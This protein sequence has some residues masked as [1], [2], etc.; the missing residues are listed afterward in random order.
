M[1]GVLSIGQLTRSLR[2]WKI[3]SGLELQGMDRPFDTPTAVA[4]SADGRRAV[5]F[6]GILTV[7]DV[8]TGKKE[9]SLAEG[10]S[11]LFNEGVALSAN[12][13]RAISG[14]E[15]GFRVW[16]LES[17]RGYN[18]RGHS[19]MVSDVALTA[20]GRRAVS[21]CHDGT[22]RIWELDLG[23][24][25]RILQAHSDSVGS[26]AISADGRRV[27]SA[28]YDGTVKIWDADTGG[29]LHSFQALSGFVQHGVAMSADG[30]RVLFGSADGILNVWNTQTGL[31]RP[32]LT[33]HK[34]MSGV[35]LS[36]D[37]MRALSANAEGQVTAWDLE[38]GQPL[39]TFTCDNPVL[40]CALGASGTILAGDYGGGVHFLSLET[41]GSWRT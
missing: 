19:Q 34:R 29:L 24:E 22:L 13:R 39:A 20:D 28:S 17:G 3:D 32:I 26:V 2:V 31:Q 37:G 10:R 36:P 30:R 9:Y 33:G 35:A 4:V 12:G 18:V 1:G 23:L 7:W 6:D 16:S 5:S 27:A 25:P 40:C 41:L 15:N 8:S 21:A 11:P 14:Y 38:T